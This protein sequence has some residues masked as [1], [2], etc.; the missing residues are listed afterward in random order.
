MIR[1]FCV[2]LTLFFFS[3]VHAQGTD[4]LAMPIPQLGQRIVSF[5]QEQE[6]KKVGRGE[7]WDLASEALNN[8]GATWDGGYAFGDLV[9]WRKDEIRPGDI[10]Q[11][12]NVEVETR[13][14]NRITRERYAK[15][16]LWDESC[17]KGIV[18]HSPSER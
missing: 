11:F 5:V 15:H 9:D 8:A 12:E 18:H 17:G 16:T 13:T 14:G 10:V 1:S 2:L 3:H 7:C 4:S 6:G